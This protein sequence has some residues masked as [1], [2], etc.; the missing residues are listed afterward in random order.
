MPAKLKKNICRR[1]PGSVCWNHCLEVAEVLDSP[2]YVCCEKSLEPSWLFPLEMQHK[3]LIGLSV[4]A[5]S[6]NSLEKLGALTLMDS[7]PIFKGLQKLQ[8]R[9]GSASRKFPIFKDLISTFHSCLSLGVAGFLLQLQDCPFLRHKNTL[10]QNFLL[11][12]Y[13]LKA[14]W[15]LSHL[16]S[17]STWIGY[18]Q[19]ALFP[20][21]IHRIYMAQILSFPYAIWLVFSRIFANKRISVLLIIV[22]KVK[23]PWKG[24]RTLELEP[25]GAGFG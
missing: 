22:W 24:I 5:K 17:T 9:A 18:I 7:A 8:C 1:F 12:W 3:V 16:K 25:Q 23:H 11:F 14:G 6:L 10:T 21:P 19:K 20:K 15:V 4:T 2:R 13:I